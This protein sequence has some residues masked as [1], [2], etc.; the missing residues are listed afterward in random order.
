LT[1]GLK[2]YVLVRGHLEALISRAVLYDLV[3]LGCEHEVKGE[4]HFGIWS[5]GRF[6]PMATAG[7]L[8]HL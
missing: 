3:E 8:A 7:D 5:G 4:R 2:P 6:Y 1:G